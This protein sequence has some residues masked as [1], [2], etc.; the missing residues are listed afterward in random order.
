MTVLCF[1]LQFNFLI[2]AQLFTLDVFHFGAKPDPEHKTDPPTDTVH[3]ETQR[4]KYAKYGT[5]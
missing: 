4:H 1:H 3:S 2:L 5:G